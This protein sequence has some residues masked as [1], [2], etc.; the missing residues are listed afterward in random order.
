ML[1]SIF[2]LLIFFWC[3][4]VYSRTNEIRKEKGGYKIYRL[5]KPYYIKGAGGYFHLDKLKEAGG[6]SIR[7]WDIESADYILK[8]AEK[9]DLTVAIT[10]NIGREREGF[11]YNNKELVK[12]QLD[13]VKK[14][15]LK[16]KNNPALMI[17]IIGNE[18]DLLATNMNIWNALNGICKMIHREDPDHLVTTTLAGVPEHHIREIIKRCP[19][20]D[21]LSINA[22]K[23]LSYVPFKIKSSGWTKPY[24]ITEWGSSGYWESEKTS[25]NASLEGTGNEKAMELKFRY[26]NGVMSDTLTCLG[27]Y[28]FYWGERQERTHTFLNLILS[29]GHTTPSVDALQFLWTGQWPQNRAPKIDSILI[30][31]LNFKEEIF[32][33]PGK[34]FNVIAFAKDPDE[35]MVYFYWEVFE[36][37]D[38]QKE[39]GDL[40]TIPE[41]LMAYVWPEK[42]P[43]T[44][45]YTPVKEGAYRLFLFVY[46]E[47]NHATTANTPF[48]VKQSK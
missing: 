9:Y 25:W 11:D 1:K 5:G 4:T 35:E 10:L 45:L 40:E 21:L 43:F 41:K 48:Y 17:W 13:E 33:E 47:N 44:K 7:T 20:L 30:N 34:E 3:S 36:E 39:G 24:I 31:N 26:V 12:K 29:S 16:Y 6:N 8:E 15:V 46:D 22:F 38:S 42:E 32:L 37:S 19:E 28:V 23:D 27:S 18:P 2:I 14:T